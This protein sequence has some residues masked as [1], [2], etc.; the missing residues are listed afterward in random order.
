MRIHEQKGVNLRPSKQIKVY[1]S[2][3]SFKKFEASGACDIYGQN[4]V[5]S[6]DEMKFDLSG[7]SD[8]SMELNAPKVNADLSGA[9]NIKLKGNTKDL[10][11][12]GSGSTDIRC[13]ELMAENTDIRISGA[14]DAEVFASVNLNVKVSGA[15]DVKY[16]D[17][18]TVNQSITGAG[19][20]KKIN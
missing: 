20:V 6:N 11:I 8:V 4:V 18:A 1:V 3:P 5:V 17:N 14:G 10:K 12:S 16:K 2:A 7:S 19:S 15:G 9:C 13:F